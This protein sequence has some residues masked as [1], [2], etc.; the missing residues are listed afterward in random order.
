M[1]GAQRE[2][3]AES[4]FMLIK[5]AHC[6]ITGD[7]YF[8]PPVY[9]ETKLTQLPRLADLRKFQGVDHGLVATS[10]L[11]RACELA[12]KVSHR[13][14]TIYALTKYKVSVDLYSTFSRALDPTVSP[15]LE[16]SGNP[17]DQVRACYAIVIAYS[18]IEELGLG[19][20]ASRDRP[21]SLAD[22][23]WN[24]LVRSDLENMLRA[25]GVDTSEAFLWCVRG[26]KTNLEARR[27][28]RLFRDALP[29]P[30]ARWDVRDLTVDIVDAI[31][32]ASWLRS[33]VAAHKLRPDNARLVSAYDVANVQW[34]VRRLLLEQFGFWKAWFR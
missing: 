10:G 19:V 18:V 8:G 29:A 22:G 1:I 16:R 2:E 13:W 4:A 24:P 33:N 34:L 31:A 5:A 6:A 30:W 32:H 25:A 14:H 27:P 17:E 28:A 3:V 26:G 21:S 9:D 12:A 15:T 11:W 7:N 20:P 23:S